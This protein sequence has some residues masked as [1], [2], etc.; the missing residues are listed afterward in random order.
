MISLLAMI[1][2]AIAEIVGCFTFWEWVKSNKSIFWLI[3]GIFFLCLFAY[4]LTFIDENQAGRAYAVYGAI[5]I[6]F[7]LLW[8]WF[9]EGYQPTKFDVL[10]GFI[11]LFGA[12]V[13]IMGKRI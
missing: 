1:G 3:P 13:I 10:G 5:Y 4:L 7:S 11:C 12:W 8:L 2:A 9:I 6:V